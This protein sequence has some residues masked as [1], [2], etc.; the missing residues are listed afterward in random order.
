MSPPLQQPACGEGLVFGSPVTD[1]ALALKWVTEI[2]PCKSEGNI[3][4]WSSGSSILQSQAVDG[5]AAFRPLT[6][7]SCGWLRSSVIPWFDLSLDF[8]TPW[9]GRRRSS[10][11]R[12]STESKPSSDAERS[13]PPVSP[14][15]NPYPIPCLSESAFL[16]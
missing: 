7:Y 1:S 6:G 8:D 13:H 15:S 2:S 5:H 16:P 11:N 10:A 4:R 12:G 14:Q 3:G 9:F